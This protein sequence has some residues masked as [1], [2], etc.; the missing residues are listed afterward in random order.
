VFTK[1]TDEAHR[2]AVFRDDGTSASTEL[3][4]RSFL[5]HDLVHYAVEAEAHI[6]DGFYGLLATGTSLALLNERDRP[7][8]SAGL[9]LAERLVGPMQSVH[10]ERLSPELYLENVGSVAPDIVTGAFV[11]N[12]LDCLRRL[13]GHWRATAYGASMEYRW[14][15]SCDMAGP[16]H[17]QAR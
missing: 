10:N 4:S 16:T 17:T 12:V 1:L 14:P 2:F 8:L 13:T 15:P 9:T 11:D 6:L 5:L 3:E 7:E